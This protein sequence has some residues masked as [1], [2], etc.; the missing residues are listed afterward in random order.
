MIVE[1]KDVL[2]LLE[3]AKTS[4]PKSLQPQLWNLKNCDFVQKPKN[5]VFGENHTTQR[6]YCCYRKSSTVLWILNKVCIASEQ[7]L[8]STSFKKWYQWRIL[9]WMSKS[10][11]YAWEILWWNFPP[12]N[13]IRISSQSNRI[14]IFMGKIISL[15]LRAL[16]RIEWI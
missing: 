2:K 12:E 7:H 1:P 11:I 10:G 14:A 6:I 8:K 16:F 13:R 15:F 4:T 9:S 3:R 5:K